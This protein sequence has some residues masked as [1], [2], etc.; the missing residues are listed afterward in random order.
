MP[1]K[2]KDIWQHFCQGDLRTSC[3]RN[4]TCR[5][6]GEVVRGSHFLYFVKRIK[7]SVIGE[8]SRML[9]H[10]NRCNSYSSQQ[11]DDGHE[12]YDNSS[13]FSPVCK[14][15]SQRTS[16]V[17]S[18]S[19]A[20]L[21]QTCSDHI[22]MPERITVSSDTLPSFSSTSKDARLQETPV[23]AFR[24]IQKGTLDTCKGIFLY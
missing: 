15:K 18:P 8:P 7:F 19:T 20:T 1:G 13:L 17:S 5:Y 12:E 24:P 10:L 22:T 14:S 4:A 3:N 9:A 23:A 2:L 6:C 16:F 11:R 21:Q